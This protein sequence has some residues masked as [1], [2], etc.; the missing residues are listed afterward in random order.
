MSCCGKNREA[1]KSARTSGTTGSRPAATTRVSYQGESAVLL[2]GPH[3][4]SSYLFTPERR[5]LDVDA[6]DLAAILA[7]GLFRAG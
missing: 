5:E 2:R 6:R 3:T 4:G 1:L 7:T